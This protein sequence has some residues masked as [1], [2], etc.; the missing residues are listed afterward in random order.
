M[1]LT[2]YAV[3][4]FK[5]VP[6]YVQFLISKK[7]IE[8]AISILNAIIEMEGEY[9]LSVFICPNSFW[10]FNFLDDNLRKELSKSSADYVVFPTNLYARYLLVNAYNSLGQLDQCERN[11]TE[12]RILLKR[13][14][15]VEEFALMLNILSIYNFFE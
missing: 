11:N 12:F 1:C 8:K 5:D 3:Q 13:Y 2:V 6:Y 10:K 9:S 15:S 7:H 14:S 4:L